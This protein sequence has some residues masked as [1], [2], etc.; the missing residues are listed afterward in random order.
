MA[1]G[2]SSDGKGDVKRLRMNIDE[3]IAELRLH[4]AAFEAASI[5]VKHPPIHG[6]LRPFY[7][8]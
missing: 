3:S 2:G 1:A 7:H 4:H 5:K 6:H 8:T